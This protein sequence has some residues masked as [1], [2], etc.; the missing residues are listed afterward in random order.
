MLNKLNFIRVTHDAKV[1]KRGTKRKAQT[2][3][4]TPTWMAWYEDLVKY[5]NDHEG[6]M[7]LSDDYPQLT[8]WVQLQQSLFA[9][10]TL[11]DEQIMKLNEL[12]FI[13]SPHDAA[14]LARCE[15]LVKYKNAHEGRIYDHF[16]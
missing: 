4:D 6:S 14:W 8:D 2:P 5:K 3:Q 10:K 15:E 9:K 1:A 16:C 11:T 13:W 12:N 7:I